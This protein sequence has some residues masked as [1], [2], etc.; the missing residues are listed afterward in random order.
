[1]TASSVRELDRRI[2]DRV[3]T[4]IMDFPRHSPTHALVAICVAALVSAA[5][6]APQQTTGERPDSERA[7]E[8]EIDP[9]PHSAARPAEVRV[10]HLHLDLEV[11]FE[12]KTLEGVATLDLERSAPDA[13]LL[14]DTRDLEILS[15]RLG[16]ADDDAPFE[17]GPPDPILGSSLEIPLAD[18]VSRVRISYRTSPEAGALLWLSPEQTAGGAAP[19]L[20]TQSQAILAR[21]WVP[22]QDTPGVRFTY[23]ADVRV[24]PGLLALMSAENPIEA[25]PEGRYSFRMTQPIPSYLLALAVGDLEFRALD[26]RTGVYA[27]GALAD[28]AAWEFAETAEMLDRVEPP[29]GPYR[30]ERYDLL[31]LPPSFPFGGME[32]PRLTFLTPTLLAGDRS[33]VALVAHELAH[34]WSGNLVTNSNWNEFWL[35]EGFTVY[36]ERRIME[37]LHGPAYAEMLA[38]LGYQDLQ[39]EVADLGPESEDTHLRLDLAGRDPDEG[40]TDIA[41]EKGALFLRMLETSFGRDRWDP[42]LRAWFDERAFVPSDTEDFLAFLDERLLH[43]RSEEFVEAL[44]IEAWIDGPGIPGNAVIPRSSRFEEVTKNLD[45]WTSGASAGSLETDGWSSHEWLYFLR[46]LPDDVPTPRLAELDGSFGFTQSGNSEILHQW[47]HI[48]IANGYEPARPELER[49]LLEVGRRKFLAP[50]YRR[51]AGDAGWDTFARDVYSKARP[52]Y[53]AVTTATVD[54][55]FDE[56]APVSG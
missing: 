50:L 43:E 4:L 22:C 55:I 48:A 6:D 37:L 27:E 44:Q 14:L 16:D 7:E 3:Y 25:E 21:T 17:L 9:T 1:M 47:F 35:N 29:F 52:G 19:F 45:S 56:V 38:E 28:E 26:A 2:R 40:M 31:V 41:Y 20:F 49:F 18:D 11:D 36:L 24:P 12:A 33:L 34:S 15:V 23:T 42:F 39:S 51:M 13:P 32:N 46:G 53:H 54:G 30:W 10:E 8:G 5:C